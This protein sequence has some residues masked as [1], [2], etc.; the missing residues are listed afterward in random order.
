M[1]PRR[2][3]CNF[4]RKACGLDYFKSLEEGFCPKEPAKAPAK[5]RS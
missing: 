3:S 1:A 5:S 4:T 2:R